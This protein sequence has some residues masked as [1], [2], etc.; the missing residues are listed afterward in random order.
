MPNSRTNAQ[1]SGPEALA[2]ARGR[3]A[4]K[5][6]IGFQ[7]ENGA[8]YLLVRVAD[9]ADLATDAQREHA[10][11]LEIAARSP[12]AERHEP[13]ATAEDLQRAP[14]LLLFQEWAASRQLTVKPAGLLRRAQGATFWD[15]ATEAAWQRW[16]LAAAE[17]GQVLRDG[18]VTPAAG[19]AQ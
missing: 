17:A 8:A 13:G 7:A 5:Y 12:Q 2:A 3:F 10:L 18:Q 4:V 19:G 1:R 15:N 9:N 14:E 11:D 16:K 6:G